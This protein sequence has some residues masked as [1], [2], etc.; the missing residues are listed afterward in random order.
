[1]CHFTRLDTFD[2]KSL[3]ESQQS[4][5]EIEEYCDRLKAYTLPSGMKLLCDV[6]TVIPR[7]FVPEPK[8]KQVFDAL[9]C[10]AHPGVKASCRL[11]KA[12]TIGL[13]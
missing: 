11:I 10:I 12:R 4:D 7:P 1:M 3:A 6:S 8:R 5:T 13:R 9:H 2:L